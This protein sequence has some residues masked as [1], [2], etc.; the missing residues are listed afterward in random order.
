MTLEQACTMA[1]YSL[2]QGIDIVIRQYSHYDANTISSDRLLCIKEKSFLKT[3]E[4]ISS[5]ILCRASSYQIH[6]IIN[7]CIRNDISYDDIKNDY[8]E[9]YK[10]VTHLIPIF[11]R[12]LSYYRYQDSRSVH[13]A[14]ISAL[15]TDTDLS[16]GYDCKELLSFDFESCFK[17][18]ML[19]QAMINNVISDNDVR[20]KIK[21]MKP[22]F[23]SE[24]YSALIE[25]GLATPHDIESG[26]KDRS[27]NV[28]CVVTNSY[29]FCYK[30]L[31]SIKPDIDAYHSAVL[32][33]KDVYLLRSLMT[34]LADDKMP[35]LLGFNDAE[36]TRLIEIR[37]NQDERESS[38]QELCILDLEKKLI[39]KKYRQTSGE[40]VGF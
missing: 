23:R 19:L 5:S 32:K 21:T 9:I 40:Q 12:E 35:Y 8:P 33:C 11:L 1:K 16:V 20:N 15:F 27:S 22:D 34:V 38:K 4:K 3:V 10:L 37:L 2:Y 25:S 26:L 17:R 36:L 13:G 28:R 29:V 7:Y 31:Y 30:T 6:G 24:A 39:D 14:L 18:A